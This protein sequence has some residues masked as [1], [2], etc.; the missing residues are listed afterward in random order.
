MKLMTAFNTA[1]SAL[2]E[3][4]FADDGDAVDRLKAK[5][6]RALG[7]SYH[8][9]AILALRQEYAPDVRGVAARLFAES[10]YNGEKECTLLRALATSD[11]PLVRLGLVYGIEDKASDDLL[12]QLVEDPHP[13]VRM[14][15]QRIAP[16]D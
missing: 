9:F 10:V 13:R 7:G 16:R 14:E 3:S 12:Q 6:A 11:Q 8:D 1:A 5:A 2:E 15:A 4:L